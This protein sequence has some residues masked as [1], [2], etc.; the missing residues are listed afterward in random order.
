MANQRH[1]TPA[2]GSAG[3]NACRP[4]RYPER[5]SPPAPPGPTPSGTGIS[6]CVVGRPM[7]HRFRRHRPRVPAGQNPRDAQ[8]RCTHMEACIVT[9]CC[10]WRVCCAIKL[11]DLGG[12]AVTPTGTRTQPVARANRQ[13]IPRAARKERHLSTGF[14]FDLIFHAGTMSL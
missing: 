7:P 9:Y 3:C 2:I 11:P 4:S 14:F 1:G 8:A 5:P 10:R 12:P 6:S 13:Y